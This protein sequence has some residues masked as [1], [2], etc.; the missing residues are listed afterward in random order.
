MTDPNS[1]ARIIV[2]EAFNIRSKLGPGMLESVYESIFARQL[3]RQG[4]HVERQVPVTFEFERAIYENAFKVDLWVA[5]SV[6]VEIK[7]IRTFAPVHFQQIL[8][9]LKL[10]GC[11]LGLLINF[12]A[13]SMR[14][15]IKRIANG[16]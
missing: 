15:G 11:K 1:I 2:N 13:P 5:R 12:G 8:S 7:V 4:L 16:L 14:E 3:I 6:I 9:Y 10:T